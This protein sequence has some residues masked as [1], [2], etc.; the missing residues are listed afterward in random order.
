MNQTLEK[1]EKYPSFGP[2]SGLFGPNLGP[3]T[4]FGGFIS[5]SS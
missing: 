4:F 3:Q 1:E 5:T 2:N